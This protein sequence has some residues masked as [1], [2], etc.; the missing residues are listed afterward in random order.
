MSASC[1]STWRRWRGLRL[2]VLLGDRA[3]PVSGDDCYALVCG[4][5]GAAGA[6]HEKTSWD[7]RL[8]GEQADKPSVDRHP[9][10]FTTP[11]GGRD[12]AIRLLSVV[13]A[14]RGRWGN[15]EI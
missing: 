7:G 15:H 6:T 2:T 1:L 8:L 4:A 13:A 12:V 11:A 3:G 5:T 9:K 14:D 10:R